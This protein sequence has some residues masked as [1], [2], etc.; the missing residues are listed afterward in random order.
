MRKLRTKIICSN[1][2][3]IITRAVKNNIFLNVFKVCKPQKWA[4]QF[5][6]LFNLFELKI[7]GSYLEFSALPEFF[8]PPLILA[9]L[10]LGAY[11]GEPSEALSLCPPTPLWTN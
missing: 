2:I 11:H 4:E 9:E 10:C 5:M 1:A 7:L 6:E 3:N 8:L